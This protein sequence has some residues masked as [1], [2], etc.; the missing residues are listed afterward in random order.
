MCRTEKTTYIIFITSFV[1]ELFPPLSKEDIYF[2][3]HLY[4]KGKY[5]KGTSYKLLLSP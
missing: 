5:D 1:T 3:Y 2:L 4:T